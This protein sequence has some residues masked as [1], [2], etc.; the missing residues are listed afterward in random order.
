[1]TAEIMCAFQMLAGVAYLW[2]GIKTKSP[3]RIILAPVIMVLAVTL[4]R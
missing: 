2:L 4:L 1:M 3:R